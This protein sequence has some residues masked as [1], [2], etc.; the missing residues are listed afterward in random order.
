MLSRGVFVSVGADRYYMNERA[1][2]AFVAAQRRR[3]RAVAAILFV[4]FVIV[5]LLFLRW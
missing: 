3:A 1:A 4:V 5:L 2:E